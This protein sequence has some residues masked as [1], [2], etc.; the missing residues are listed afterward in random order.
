MSE[1]TDLWQ[2]EFEREKALRTSVQ[3]A[4]YAIVVESGV[5]CRRYADDPRMAELVKLV[6][7]RNALME[8]F[9]KQIPRTTEAMKAVCSTSDMGVA[10]A[11]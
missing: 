9:L 5:L 10:D 8:D 6:A 1:A 3:V 7:R 11:H 2:M 4:E